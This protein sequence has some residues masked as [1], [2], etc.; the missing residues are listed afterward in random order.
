MK[1]DKCEE[2][3]VPTCD[4]CGSNKR[5]T[6]AHLVCNRSAPPPRRCVS[7]NLCV[8]CGTELQKTNKTK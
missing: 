7:L 6:L 5:F 8:P 3:V 1:S 2:E 4:K